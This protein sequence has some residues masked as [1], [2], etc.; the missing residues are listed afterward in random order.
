MS[1]R[2]YQKD[3]EICEK[4]NS[5][6]WLLAEETYIHF[7]RT[8]APW[9][10]RRVMELESQ[11]HQAEEREAAVLSAFK[12]WSDVPSFFNEHFDELC[13]AIDAL[14]YPSQPSRYQLMEK[15]VEAASLVNSYLVVMRMKDGF[16]T[17][18][19][20]EERVM[21]L[22]DAINAY[23]KAIEMTCTP[24]YRKVAEYYYPSEEAPADES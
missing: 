22:E 10:I 7:A 4:M 11:L 1:E 12:A 18:E 17:P 16:K 24:V 19:E 14:S 15:V 2:D 3:L 8:V 13:G 21:E 6:E 20:L 23:D 9:Y 5:G